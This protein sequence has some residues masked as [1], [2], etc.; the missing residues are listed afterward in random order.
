VNVLYHW[1]SVT[2]PAEVLIIEYEPSGIYKMLGTQLAKF[3]TFCSLIA[4]RVSA[5]ELAASLTKN[6]MLAKKRYLSG[7]GCYDHGGRESFFAT[8]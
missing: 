1:K 3:P 5:V 8:R 7:N 2:S 6:V 4:E